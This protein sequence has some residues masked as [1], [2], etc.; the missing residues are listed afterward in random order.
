MTSRR[1]HVLTLPRIVY[2]LVSALPQMEVTVGFSEPMFSVVLATFNRAD[3]VMDAV[4]SVLAQTLN[5]FELIIVDDRSTDDTL[6]V[7]AKIADSRVTVVVN[8]RSKGYAGARNTGILRARARWVCQIDSDDLWP[9]DMLEL[10]AAAIAT[11][12]A[13]VGILYGT[14]VYLDTGSGQVRAVRTAERA[15]RLHDVLLEDH[16]MS[17]CGAALRTD[18][19]VAIG[20]YDETLR[21]QADSDILIRL[22]QDWAVVAVP[23]ARYV[24]REG[25]ADRLMVN[26]GALLAFVQLYEKH[27]AELVGLPQAR[28][29]QLAKILDLAIIYGNIPRVVWAWPRLVPSIWRTPAIG[30]EFLGQ[31]KKVASLVAGRARHRWQGLLP[32]HW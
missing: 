24:V 22:S 32:T 23:D 16:F 2:T 11:A 7:L 1:V 14:L 10:M 18:A 21:Q 8:E 31:Q 25:H 15:G 20:G 17:H 29:R 4:N 28:Y 5:D 30:R 19:L 9:T 3:L 12:P 26:P 13:Q 6:D 27:A